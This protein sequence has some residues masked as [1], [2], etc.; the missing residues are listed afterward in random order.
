MENRIRSIFKLFSISRICKLLIF[1][2]AVSILPFRQP[3][4]QNHLKNV[5]TC[6]LLSTLCATLGVY[7]PMIGWFNYP[8]LAI[9]GSIVTT[10]W[11]GMSD[12]NA[13]TQMKCFALLATT[14][15]FTGIYLSPLI[16]LAVNVDPQIVMTAFLLTT[17]IFLCFTISALM[18][19]KRTYLYLGGKLP[20]N[21]LRNIIY[22]YLGLLGTGTS[23]M[24][25]LSLMNLFGRSQLIFNVSLLTDH[26][27]VI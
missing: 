20:M 25:F 9:F 13:R 7:F 23:V 8:L 2:L 12:L 5:Y 26:R 3:R 4:V 21:E 19:Q 22:E 11:L 10:I 27:I 16:N 6:L 24:L 14:A 1:L 18:T 17:L 15:F